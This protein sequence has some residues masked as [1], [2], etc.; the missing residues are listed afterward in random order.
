VVLHQSFGKDWDKVP[1]Q[2]TLALFHTLV[3]YITTRRSQYSIMGMLV[4]VNNILP[5]S[6][7]PLQSARARVCV[8][9]T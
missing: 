9:G 1:N 7:E 3:N 2:A 6:L 5:H 8:E 4:H